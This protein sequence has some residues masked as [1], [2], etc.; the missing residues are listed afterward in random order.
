VSPRHV[1]GS[2][3]LSDAAQAKLERMVKT[4]GVKPTATLLGSSDITVEALR[5]SGTVRP[6]TVVRIEAA[7]GRLK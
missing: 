4:R 2:A 7:L 6:E 1:T 3:R 5:D